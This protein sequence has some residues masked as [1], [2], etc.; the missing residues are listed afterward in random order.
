MGK[1]DI[2]GYLYFQTANKSLNIHHQPGFFDALQLIQL[3]NN[4]S[5][6]RIPLRSHTS[7]TF[8]DMDNDKER[9]LQYKFKL[10]QVA[11]STGDKN[12]AYQLLSC[13]IIKEGSKVTF[14]TQKPNKP[15]YAKIKKKPSSLYAY[16]GLE[17]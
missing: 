8:S 16:K 15:E 7:L 4:K 2:T 14:L 17:D 1:G 6:Q 10:G 5:Y 11:I 12:P 3:Q 9:L 13:F